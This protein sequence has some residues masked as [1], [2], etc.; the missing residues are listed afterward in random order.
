MK[1]TS[2]IT[3]ILLLF[4]GTL[5]SQIKEGTYMVL[6][7]YY[8]YE[9]SVINEKIIIKPCQKYDHQNSIDRETFEFSL[10]PGTNTYAWKGD[11]TVPLTINGN[12]LTFNDPY[13]LKNP[14]PMML[15]HPKGE[16]PNEG[17]LTYF[18]ETQ[19][20]YSPARIRITDKERIKNDNCFIHSI[21]TNEF[22]NDLIGNFTDDYDKNMQMTLHNDF[23]GSYLGHP[24][25]WSIVSD[26]TRTIKKWT[27]P[28][29]NYLI[30][31]MMEFTSTYPANIDPPLAGHKIAII[32]GVIVDN[33]TTSIGR[34]N[35]Q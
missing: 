35:K 32:E 8:N 34:M 16:L 12:M 25:T 20:G 11:P 26:H 30:H 4:T 27:Y 6:Y 1:A 22:Q 19:G 9:L 10:I 2:I 29:G 13:N 5:F 21:K 14:I 24:I 3:S 7:K 18:D 31:I 28:S 33:S 15:I 17:V 23:T